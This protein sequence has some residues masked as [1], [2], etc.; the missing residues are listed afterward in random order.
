MMEPA[1]RRPRARPSD[2]AVSDL[3]RYLF[4][5]GTHTELYERLGAHPSG[6]RGAPTTRFAVWAPN[7]ESV[8]VIGDFNDWTKG[9][10]LLEPVGESGIFEG[11]LAGVGP[12][13][14]YKYHIRSRV[15]GYRVDKADPVGFAH[16]LPPGTASVVADLSYRWGDAEWMAERAERFRFDGPVAFYEVHL[17]SW[18]RVPEEGHR[19]LTYA[20]LAPRLAEYVRSMGF[21][22]V[23]FLPVTEHPFYA[24][25]GYEPTGLFAPTAR[26]GPPTGLMEL[27]DTLHRAGIGVVLDWVPGHFPRDEHGLAF[28]DGTHLYEHEDPRRGYHPDWNTF[29]YNFGRHEVRSFLASSAAFWLDKYHADGLRVDGVASMIYR[30]YS[31]REGEWVPA[32]G[33]GRENGEAISF[34][35][36]LNEAL[37]ARFPGTQTIAEE[38][39]AWPQVSRPTSGGGLG[40]G[41]KW[42]MGW[43]H[44]TLEYFRQD[45]IHRRHWHHRLT[46]RGLYA[47]AENFVLPLS[48]DEVVHLKG[49]LL[50]RMPGDAWQKFANL[51]LLFAYQY[52]TPGKKLLFMGDEFGQG[53]EWHHDESLD[54][55]LL[56]IDWHAG[57]SR[58]VARLNEVYRATPALSARD[59][60]PEG[61]T[62]LEADDA[63]QSVYSFVRAG[64]RPEERVIVVLNATPVPR[65][66]FRVGAPCPGRYRALLN[67]DAP[68]FR[69]SGVG[70]TGTVATEPHGYHGQGDS[71]VVD[72]PPL[73]ALYLGWEPG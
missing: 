16:E 10:D 18:R 11:N 43:M 53:R 24:S 57:L 58:F 52:A 34:L 32:P 33:G 56:G 20:E 22:H 66:G 47:L 25:W 48:H 17:G 70:P 68:E 41:Y 29:I 31:R 69:G 23:E 36:W 3:D 39:T 67:S 60:A 4:N 44:D 50:A 13:A 61:F 14:R 42:D 54:W 19:P 40:F 1:A 37:Y 9:H 38:S 72:L 7:A 26:Y 55:D 73:G 62:W 46:F 8:S 45:P 71:L 15:A 28:F 30:D 12:G 63:S 21:T 35:R 59:Y 6:R 64:G 5:E 2:R 65:L 49:S 27:I 51:R